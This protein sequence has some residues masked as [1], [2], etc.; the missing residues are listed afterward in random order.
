MK[1]LRRLHL[2]IGL[3]CSVVILLEAVTGLLLLNPGLLGVSK[4]AD[5]PPAEQWVAQEGG[6]NA[7]GE[8]G[9]VSRPG[10]EFPPAGQGFSVLRVIKQL[11]TG[12][13]GGA[14]LS[15]LL[16]AGAVAVMV[17]T[18]TGIVLTIKVLKVAPRR[19]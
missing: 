13:I 8:N 17:L 16:S 3:F 11:H 9:A 18:I 6:Q 10:R 14:D 4:A 5:R 2:W 12:R 1:S 19:E 7:S 15:W